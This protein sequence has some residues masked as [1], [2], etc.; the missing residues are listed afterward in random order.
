MPCIH[1]VLCVFLLLPNV[2]L[3]VALVA[4]VGPEVFWENKVLRVLK[5]PITLITPITLK[6]PKAPSNSRVTKMLPAP[7]DDRQFSSSPP[8]TVPT[9][10]EIP[11]VPAAIDAPEVFWE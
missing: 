6:A 8:H 7:S 5:A 10:P 1:L 3:P 11:D 4:L 9:A 2:K